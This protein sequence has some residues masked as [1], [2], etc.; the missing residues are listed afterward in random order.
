MCA[1]A[2]KVLI[3]FKQCLLLLGTLQKGLSRAGKRIT[4]VCTNT[5][6]LCFYQAPAWQVLS[7]CCLS[8]PSTYDSNQWPNEKE[9]S[10]IIDNK[11][12]VSRYLKKLHQLPT[13]LNTNEPISIK[14]RSS[15]PGTLLLRSKK[16]RSNCYKL[17]CK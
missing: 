5:E 4:N 16:L 7:T 9:V 8:T 3:F 12:F 14:F 1:F 10:Y 2:N 17:G 6:P 13:C 11:A 15:S